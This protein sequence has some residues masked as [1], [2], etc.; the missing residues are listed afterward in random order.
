MRGLFCLIFVLSAAVARAEEIAVESV[1]VNLI[2]E[3]SVPA[4]EAGVL[5]EVAVKEGQ[6][7]NTGDALARLGDREAVLEVGA[8]KIALEQARELAANDVSKRRAQ[9]TLKLAKLE[10]AKSEEANKQVE[11]VVTA[12]QL[13]KL[14]IEVENALL[15]I[16]QAEK[17]LAAAQ[18]GVEAATNRLQIAERAVERRRIVSQIDGVVVD[19]RRN[20]GEWLK[21]GETVL[22]VVRDDHL[23]AEGFVHVDKLAGDWRGRPVRLEVKVGSGPMQTFIG[24]I[25]FVAPEVNPVNRQVRVWADIDNKLGTLRAGLS[26]KM[27][28]LP[29][30]D[31]KQAR[32]EK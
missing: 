5:V 9:Q 24:E 32:G 30:A 25:A 2:A 31:D 20:Q 16:E 3:A 15:E 17:E 11:K 1:I 6:R 12:A 29:K 13:E 10:L 7:V 21:P 28:V 8:A 23:R 4:E 26:G 18:R 19:I 14:K 27:F 22:R